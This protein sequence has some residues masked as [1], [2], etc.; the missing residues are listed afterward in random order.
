MFNSKVYTC[1]MLTECLD[2]CKCGS[3]PYVSSEEEVFTIR[4]EDRCGEQFSGK[5]MDV[6][7]QWN[8]EMRKC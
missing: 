8:Q 7:V 1:L 6:A 5:K 4:C 3:S 2:Q